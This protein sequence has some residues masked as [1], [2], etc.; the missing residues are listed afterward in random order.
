MEEIIKSKQIACKKCD[1]ILRIMKVFSL[2]FFFCILSM[3][4]ENVYPQQKELS[5]DLRNVTITKAIS[6][7]EKTSDYVFL[8]TDEA[9]LELNK[10]TSVRANKES[11]QNILETI[12]KGTDL[13][14]SVVERQVSIYKDTD[15]KASEKPVTVTEEIAQQKKSITGRVTDNEGVPIIGANIVEVGTTNGTVTD[16]D[17]NFSLDVEDSAVLQVS[18]IGYLTQ[19]IN[20]AGKT[21]ID[22][23][24]Q[25]DTQSLEEL[26]VVGYGVQKKKLVTGATI[27][28]GG[29]DLTKL[30]HVSHFPQTIDKEI[31]EKCINFY[32]SVF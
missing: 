32:I 17:G 26:V 8:I 22:I 25:E 3:S 20:T 24:L 19:N 9:Q 28:V 16:V 13:G 2:L 1:R 21:N 18:Y 12:L 29:D 11:I 5:L 6:E 27:Q 15:S 4:A 10:R 14:Y 31:E 7:I 30:T 23:V